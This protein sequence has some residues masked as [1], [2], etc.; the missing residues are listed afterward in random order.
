MCPGLDI[1]VPE[2]VEANDAKPVVLEHDPEVLRD[3]VRL[4]G[5]AQIIDIDVAGVRVAVPAQLP[6]VLLPLLH[7]KKQFPKLRNQRHRPAAGFVFHPI[8][9]NDPL[10]SV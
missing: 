4:V 3:I 6:A 5:N 7:P 2:T 8:L 10:L 1:W 9:G